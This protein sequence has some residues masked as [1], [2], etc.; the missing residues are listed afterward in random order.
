MQKINSLNTTS[1]FMRQHTI[2]TTCSDDAM[3][4]DELMLEDNIEIGADMEM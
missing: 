2:E 3:F 1:F 4:I